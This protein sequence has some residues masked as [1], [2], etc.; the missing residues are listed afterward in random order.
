MA[1]LSR[2]VTALLIAAAAF[3]GSQASAA[4]LEVTSGSQRSFILSAFGA[5]GQSF[6]ALDTDLTSFGFQFNALNPGNAN[7]PFTFNLYAGETLTGVALAT[8]VFTLPTS[9]NTRTPTWFDFDI[10]GTTVAI[11]QKY[12]AVLSSSSSRNGV[13]M[14]PDINI[15]TGAELSG[16]AY[17]GGKALFT[18]E[19]YPNC[20]RTGNCDLNF[21]VTGTTAVSAVPEPATWAMM[22][23]GFGMTGLTLRRR[24]AKRAGRVSYAI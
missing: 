3:A 11:G 15:F 2:A 23:A 7:L 13:V 21:R 24:R 6:T 14:G 19:V 9:I 17:A 22:L 1:S 10:T 12:T 8:R 18:R 16:D 5:A 20:A 4:T